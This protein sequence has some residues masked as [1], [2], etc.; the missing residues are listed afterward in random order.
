MSGLFGSQI[1]AGTIPKEAFVPG[2]VDGDVLR[3]ECVEGKHI[4]LST[5]E[6][7][8]LDEPLRKKLNEVGFERLDDGLK[9]KIDVVNSTAVWAL[10]V[11]F[12]NFI[13]MI[14]YAFYYFATR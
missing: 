12:I 2:C 9:K 10:T 11:S 14:F 6:E 13:I 3:E 5:I 1:Q 8:R 4:Q 7:A